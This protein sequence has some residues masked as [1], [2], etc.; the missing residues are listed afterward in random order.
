MF[1]TVLKKITVNTPKE[2]Q[3]AYDTSVIS[4]RYLLHTTHTF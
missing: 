3:S 1:E 4:W 2:Q